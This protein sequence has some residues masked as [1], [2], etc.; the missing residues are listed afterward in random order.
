MNLPRTVG[1]GVDISPEDL[2]SFAIWRTT[3]VFAVDDQ[4]L[5][6]SRFHL[7][8]LGVTLTLNLTRYGN[9][10]PDDTDFDIDLDDVA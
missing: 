6:S 2:W 1:F 3:T 9:H 4:P 10:L 5:T 8:I 7:A